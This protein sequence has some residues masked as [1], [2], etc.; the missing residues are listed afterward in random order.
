[1]SDNAMEFGIATL[2]TD[3]GMDCLKLATVVEELGFSSLF[4]GDHTHIPASRETPYPNPPYGDLPRPYYRIMD[5]LVAMASMAVVTTRLE[6]GTAVCLVVERDP[7]VLAKQ[8]AT[9]DHVSCGRV[10]LGVGAGWNREEMRNHG[11][12]PRVRMRVMRERVEAMKAIWTQELAEYH[13]EFV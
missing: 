7:I 11:T 5:P 13:G 4:L 9:L 10:L 6:L 2:V 12:D 3:E 8:V 1:M